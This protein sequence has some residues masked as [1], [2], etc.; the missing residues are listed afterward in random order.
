M[1]AARSLEE[2]FPGAPGGA[3]VT[4]LVDVRSTTTGVSAR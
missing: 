2:T 1:R 3:V 4:C